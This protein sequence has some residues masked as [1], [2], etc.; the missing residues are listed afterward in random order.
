MRRNKMANEKIIKNEN[1]GQLRVTRVTC[2]SPQSFYGS[3]IKH[4][5]WFELTLFESEL[6][7]KYNNDWYHATKTIARIALTPNQ[8]VELITNVGR[9][10]GVPC[11][12]NFADGSEKE[13]FISE[14]EL[15]KFHID[16]EEQLSEIGNSIKETTKL[17]NKLLEKGRLNK[18][19]KEEA[20]SSVNKI[21][22]EFN[23]NLPY[24]RKCFTESL[25]KGVTEFKNMVDA[26]LTHKCLDLGINQLQLE[27]KGDNLK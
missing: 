3:K 17:L 16:F 21:N 15:S 18:S 1:Q 11:T 27:N 5:E 20:I 7:R 9:G 10:D 19:E 6:N 25:D 2:G 22:R 14:D 8:F 23:E 4:T 26:H 13:V 24:I 12:I